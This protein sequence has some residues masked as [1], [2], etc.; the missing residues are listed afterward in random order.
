MQAMAINTGS[1]IFQAPVAVVVTYQPDL[2]RLEAVLQALTSQVQTFIAV[3]N[4]SDEKLRIAE[5][6]SSFGAHSFR[7][8]AT[9]ASPPLRT[10]A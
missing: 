6:V 10:A 4:G 9:K 8:S 3:D 5:L 7:C 2:A 1:E